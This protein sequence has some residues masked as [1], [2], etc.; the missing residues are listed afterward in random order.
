M[1]QGVQGTAIPLNL[2]AGGTIGGDLTVVGDVAV[3]GDASINLTTVVADSTIIDI[4]GTEAFLVRKD[5]DGGDVFTVDTTNSNV[6]LAATGKLYLDGGGNTYLY[7][8]SADKVDLVV[9]GVTVLEIA[10]AGGGASD[11][12]A[13]QALNKFYFDGGS[14]TYIQ[15]S[16]ADVLDIYVGGANMMKFTESTTDTVLITSNLTVGVDDTGNDVRIYSAT[17]NEGLLY[18]A[19]E[20]EL[21]LLLT[22]KLK[23]HDIGGGEEIYASSNGHLEINAGTTLDIT[24]PTV[25]INAATELNIDGN[26][27]LNGTLDV[28]G[29]LTVGADG[30]GT[31]VIFYSGTAGDNFTWDASEEKLTI[32]GTNGQ[33]ALDIPDGNVTITDDLAVDGTTNLDNTDIDGTFTQDAGNVVFNEDSGDYDFRVESNG[34]ANMLFVDGGSDAVIIGHSASDGKGASLQVHGTGAHVVEVSRWHNSANGPNINLTKSRGGSVGT[35]AIVQ[36]DDTIG[37]IA[38]LADDGTNQSSTVATIK[39]EID[40]TPGEN[41]TPGRLVFS[42]TADG[43]ESV[44]ERMR[45]DATGNVG[46]GTSSPADLLHV[47]ASAVSGR[48]D[49]GNTVAILERNDHAYLQ[50]ST[51]A[52]SHGG[53]LFADDGDSAIG[54]VVYD[55]GNDHLNLRAGGH[56]GIKLDA[57]SRTSLSNN[58]SGTSN[59]IFGKLAG[60]DLASGGNYNVLIGEDAGHT[61]KLGDNNIAIGYDAFDL[62]YIDDTQDALTVDNIFIGKDAGGGDW[63][64]AASHSNIGIGSSVMDAAMNGA[65]GNTVVGHSAGSAITTSDGNT[66]IGFEALKAEDVGSGNTALG[67]QALETLD[68][69]TGY[70]VAIGYDA[71]QACAGAYYNVAIGRD[72]GKNISGSVG[73][74]VIIG[75]EAGD[76]AI[77]QDGQVLIGRSAGGA[78]TSGADNVAVGY[79]ALQHITTGHNCMA[80]GKGALSGA[81]AANAIDSDYNMAIG[82]LSMSGD[83]A[84]VKSEKNLC[85][86]VSTMDGVLNGA[87]FNTAVGHWSLNGCSSGEK[88]ATFGYEAGKDISSGGENVAIG[89]LAGNTG[90]TD[91]STGSQNTLLGAST[92]SGATGAANR[93]VV[94]YGVTG[95]ADNSVT[96]GNASVTAVYAAQ[97][98]D[99][100]VYCGGINMSL[101]QPAAAAGSMS[102]EHLDHYEEGTWTPTLTDGTD[103]AVAH[104]DNGGNYTKIGRLVTIQARVRTSDLTDAGTSNEVNGNITIGGLPF[105]NSSTKKN[106]AFS[107]SLG[108]GLNITEGESV[109]GDIDNGSSVIYLRVWNATGGTSTMQASEWTD[110]GDVV[111]TGSY[112]SA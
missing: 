20:D 13:I 85:I 6:K 57:N 90:T 40:G 100:V 15:E 49:N 41:D 78:I 98:G 47:S 91:L 46:I 29:T 45:I 89:H 23:F 61:N 109:T 59:T 76:G 84:N 44:T 88:N 42:T 104:S 50:I 43:S 70:N 48:E 10:E 19:S 54:Y 36:D 5:S 62:S 1:L 107:F 74:S 71:M 64:T 87:D 68:N 65:L 95:Q 22:T 2:S 33:T 60:D 92:I 38:W 69:D 105:A 53:I 93:T 73:A 51:N 3:S 101:N 52:S 31:D 4:T 86:G 32:T 102:S 106:A 103:V 35:E 37:S 28:S 77:T 14:D 25:D 34:N 12:M 9:G 11:Y 55:H 97:D 58:D 27:D 111:L 7:E 79:Q 80:I 83:W 26:A 81:T 63:A 72:A 21:G 66:A 82:T 16:G 94:G 17:T 112:F 18:D 30:S 24:A 96:L 75:Y 99:A 8:V 110:D 108:G 39:S 67:Y 56:I